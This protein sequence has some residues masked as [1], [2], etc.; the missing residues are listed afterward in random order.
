MR[1][2]V[3]VILL[4]TQ[5]CHAKG[6]VCLMVGSAVYQAEGF[7]AEKARRIVEGV[8]RKDYSGK[9]DYPWLPNFVGRRLPASLKNSLRQEAMAILMTEDIVSGLKRM[10][11]LVESTRWDII[12]RWFSRSSAH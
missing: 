5:I 3:L 10:G 11:V 7:S 2:C 1:S 9:V 4:I 6:S 8:L 12:D